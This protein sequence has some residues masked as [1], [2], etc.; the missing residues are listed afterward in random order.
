MVLRPYPA[1]SIALRTAL[2]EEIAILK[3]AHAATKSASTSCFT[4]RC[5]RHS[6]AIIS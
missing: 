4:F 6:E 2:E 1:G 5:E 3:V